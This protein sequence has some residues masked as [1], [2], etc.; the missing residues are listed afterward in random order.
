ML[1]GC[2]ELPMEG[3]VERS[4]YEALEKE[5]RR[6]QLL[7]ESSERDHRDPGPVS[8]CRWP[9]KSAG[10]FLAHCVREYCAAPSHFVA[11]P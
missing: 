2:S 7:L 1:S 9:F 5:V 6:L 11:K 10:S 8:S 4:K 3:Y